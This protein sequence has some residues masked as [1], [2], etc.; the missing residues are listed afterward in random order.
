[1]T[2]ALMAAGFEG[3][4]GIETLVLDPET[5]RCRVPR[6]SRGSSLR[7]VAPSPSD[8]GVSRRSRGRKTVDS[9]TCPIEQPVPA[10]SV[11]RAGP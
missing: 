1:V 7:G 9:A 2:A 6:A 5:G 8:T 10:W 11:C 4:R 3:A